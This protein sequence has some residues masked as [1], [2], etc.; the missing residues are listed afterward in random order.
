MI[1][2]LEGE[3]IE[4]EPAR[5]VLNVGGVGYELFIPLSSYDKLPP[6]GTRCKILTW[7]CIR[8]DAHTLYGFA[9]DSE[10]K[11]F[12]LLMSVSGIGPK[13]ALGA[14]SG[15]SVREL[16]SAI[17]SN[18]TKRI[19]TISGIGKK[20]AERII[21]ELKD[22]ISDGEALEVIAGESQTPDDLRARDAILALIALGF[23]QA[24]AQAAI[25]KV[26]PA[27]PAAAPVEDLV[28]RALAV[29]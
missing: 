20:T 26:L 24:D 2:F 11:F 17:V 14:L 1:T 29:K 8:E 4:K 15:M 27:L 7:L 21:V 12:L 6:P 13:T 22:K 3:L 9:S 19:S 28:R 16:K 5:L 23:K 10:R 18:D 25:R